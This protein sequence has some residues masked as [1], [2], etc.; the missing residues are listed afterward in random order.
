MIQPPK[1][2]PRGLQSAGIAKVRNASSPFGSVELRRLSLQRI[3]ASPG[4]GYRHHVAMQ[5]EIVNVPANFDA[6]LIA[7]RKN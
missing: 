1:M 4:R 7:V 6:F 5:H 2:S 3:P